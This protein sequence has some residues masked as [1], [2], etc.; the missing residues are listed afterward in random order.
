MRT[1]GY[2][3]RK[4]GSLRLAQ[5]SRDAGTWS[6]VTV[7]GG[8]GTMLVPISASMW[9]AD[10]WWLLSRPMTTVAHRYTDTTT[11]HSEVCPLDV[12]DPTGLVHERGRQRRR[13]DHIH[14]HLH[15]AR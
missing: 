5:L 13:G 15:A 4:G 7:D 11:Q 3:R 2:Y 10:Q 1:L 14:L 8:N 6:I 12:T 9:P